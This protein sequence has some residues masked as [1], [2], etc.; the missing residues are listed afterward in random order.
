MVTL[1]KRNHSNPC[2]WTAFWNPE[3]FAQTTGDS[4][5]R[6]T[7]REQVVHS[8]NV[9]ADRV[10]QLNVENVHVESRLGVA[11]IAPE[12]AKDFC[13]RHFPWEYEQFVEDM[14]GHPE[15]LIMDLEQVLD[16]LEA[17]GAYETLLRVITK[18]TIDDREEIGDL[19][20]FIV[21]Q[22]VRSHANLRAALERFKAAGVERFEYYWFL[23]QTMGSADVLFALVAPLATSHWTVY[24]TR[25]HCFPL[26]DT[27]VLV[28]PGN[29]MIALSPRMLAEIDLAVCRPQGSWTMRD[30]IPG[31]KYNEYRR[32]AIGNTYKEVIFH[33]P[34]VL[35]KWR[36]TRQFR[37][38]V[39]LARNA[40]SYVDMVERSLAQPEGLIFARSRGRSARTIRRTPHVQ[41]P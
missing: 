31:R 8:L 9:R 7:A 40:R 29:V 19:S 14:K 28:K 5:V 16:S 37:R 27:P 36:A 3:Y 15:T 11:E 21:F 41:R 12:A 2:F 34:G 35:E 23:K 18:H 4:Q 20:S 17:T 1:T 22:H 38:R 39:K 26:P 25:E 24:R 10:I 13:R 6:L 33:D 32:R 30:G